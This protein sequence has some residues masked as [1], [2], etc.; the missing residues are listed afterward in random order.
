M[1]QMPHRSHEEMLALLDELNTRLDGKAPD[2]GMF[3]LYTIGGLAMGA[4]TGDRATQDIDVVA[5]RIPR[6]VLKAARLV[7]DNHQMAHNWVNNDVAALVDADLP[8]DAFQPLYSGRNLLVLGAKPEYLLGLKLMA[9]RSQDI[10]DLVTLA[11]E[12][13]AVSSA[14]LLAICDRVFA[15]S[16]TYASERPF[17]QAVCEDIAPLAQARQAGQDTNA[18]VARLEAAYEGRDESTTPAAERATARLAARRRRRRQRR[19]AA[20][21]CGAEIRGGRCSHPRPEPG[22]ACAAGHRR[23]G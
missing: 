18:D 14:D 22:H 8:F 7:A 4:V 15:A 20:G 1:T 13:G 17:V 5:A 12:L 9:G 2:G 3:T 16:P 6:A 19:S 23:P 21:K 11:G 10:A